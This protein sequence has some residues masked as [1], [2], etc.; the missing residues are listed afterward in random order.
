MSQSVNNYGKRSAP[1]GCEPSHGLAQPPAM[2]Y[3]GGMI[4]M[5][6]PRVPDL[7][8]PVPAPDPAALLEQ[9]ATLRWENAALCAENAA[10]RVE[11]G[12]LQGRIRELEAQLGQNSSNSSHPPSSD[13]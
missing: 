6:V 9:V 1:P 8:A 4:E 12:A 5:L 7:Q 13:P 11:M 2:G 10:L 3:N